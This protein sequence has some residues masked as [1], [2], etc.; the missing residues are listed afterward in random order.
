M[1][2]LKN[3]SKSFGKNLVLDDISLTIQDGESVGLVGSNGC[4]KTTLVELLIGQIKP[5]KGS[6]TLNGSKDTY[7]KIGVQFQEGYWPPG[8]TGKNII[9]YFVKKKNM[10]TEDFEQ[11]KN[12]FNLEGIINK[13]L[14]SLSAGQR[15]RINTLLAV[16]NN[17]DYICLDEMITGLDL[18]MQLRLI[19]Y[20]KSKID[21]GKTMVIISHSPEEIETLCSTIII[22]K[23]SKIFYKNKKSA[24]V[25][26]FGSVRNMMLKF[27]DKELKSNVK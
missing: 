27:Y 19:K 8:I 11:L 20:F 26:E 17:Q 9:S 16:A 25:S 13:S 23:D 1:I 3:V 18:E 15:Q 21:E 22:L 12:V 5:D 4:G 14:S 7:K 6:I 10:N 2:E 24:V